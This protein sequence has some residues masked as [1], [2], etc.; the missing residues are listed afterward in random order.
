MIRI[1][2]SEA[3]NLEKPRSS[4]FNQSNFEGW[5]WKKNS[6]YTKRLKNSN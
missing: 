3:P 4:I 5:N 2:A 1:I 6:N